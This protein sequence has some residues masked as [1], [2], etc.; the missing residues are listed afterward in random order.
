MSRRCWRSS[1]AIVA[2]GLVGRWLETPPAEDA[3][4]VLSAD[5]GVSAVVIAVV[6]L[7]GNLF[8][9]FS[10]R[11]PSNIGYALEGVRSGIVDLGRKLVDGLLVVAWQFAR[12]WDWITH[13]VGRIFR[14]LYDMLSA[15]VQRIQR[16]LD[17]IFG[18]I[19]EFLDRVRFWV[20]KIYRDF[21]RPILD[22]IE[23]VRVFTRTLAQFGVDW[24]R[25]LDAKLAELERRIQEPFTFIL[26]KLNEISNWI[27]RIVTLDGFLQRVTLLRSL[28]R[29][30]VE[31]TNIGLNQLHTPL[32]GTGRDRYGREWR[33]REIP[34]VAAE[35]RA[36]IVHGDGPDRGRID[37]HWADLRIRLTR[38]GAF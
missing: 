22:I 14:S 36:Y 2:L 6:G 24:A 8:G 15:V 23:L 31:L 29:D 34:V 32:D 35:A 19:L 3:A 18:P 16:V 27:N 20:N 17:R 10:G 21:V 33:H 5:M 26:G 37:E 9:F 25:E 30:A 13:N 7:L 1:L 38:Y 11:A 4:R 28:L 12:V